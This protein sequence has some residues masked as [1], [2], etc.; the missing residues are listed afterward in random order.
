MRLAGTAT[1]LPR[2]PSPP[3]PPPPPLRPR[4]SSPD[5]RSGRLGSNQRSPVP[6]T[7]G[8]PSPLQP[9]GPGRGL[10]GVREVDDRGIEPRFTAVSERRLPS[11]PVVEA[12]VE[13]SPGNRT[14]LHEFTTRGLATS[15]ATQS[16]REDSNPH[17]PRQ[18]RGAHPFSYGE[19]R[20]RRESNPP[21][22]GDSQVASPDASESVWGIS[23]APS[24]IRT[25]VPGVRDRNPRPS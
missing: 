1:P 21:H 9:E 23:S 18:E 20:S 12:I 5:M 11:Q 2:S 25:R 4:P 8:L 15:L 19:E 6:E 10:G 7:G 17:R 14:L 13:A 24:G 22:P 3:P 16:R